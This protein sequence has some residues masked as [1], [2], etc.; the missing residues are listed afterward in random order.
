MAV[1]VC[2]IAE[3][4]NKMGR[5]LVAFGDD[6]TVAVSTAQIADFGLY[7]GRELTDEEHSRL[8][9]DLN[10]S[11][12][13]AGAVR[14]LGNRSLSAGEIKRKIMS[15]GGSEETARETVDWLEETGLVNDEQYAQSIASHYY[16]KGYGPAR[17][18][19][20][21]YRRGIPREFWDAVVDMSDETDLEASADGFLRKKLGG[22]SDPGDIRRAAAAL[23]RKGFSYEQAN[24]AVKRYQINEHQISYDEHDKGYYE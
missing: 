2:S 18:R 10:L 22:S 23:V 9:K 15:K 4:E 21:L 3:A 17:V 6:T 13:K 1:T 7:A 14:M 20:E 5:F 8:L 11:A 16:S 12:A 19:D 24:S